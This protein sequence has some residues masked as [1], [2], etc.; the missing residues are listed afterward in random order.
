VTRAALKLSALALLAAGVALPAACGGG[1][2]GGSSGGSTSSGTG[3]A[4]GLPPGD[5]G[6]GHVD[7]AEECDDGNADD[8]DDCTTT[9]KIPRCGDGFVQSGEECDDGNFDDGDACVAGCVNAGC[10][11]GLLHKGVEDCDDGNQDNGD[12]CSSDCKAGQGCGNGT[13]EPPE[14]CDDGNSSNADAC[15]TS[16]LKATCGDGY[17]QIGAEECDDGNADDGDFCTNACK[18]N[19]PVSYGC[20]GI[21]LG[22]GLAMD[23]GLTGDSNAATDTAQG[24]CGGLDSPEIVYAVT[25]ADTG[26]LVVTM[27]GLE[28]S[29]PVL[30]ARSVDCQ[31]GMELGC[32]DSSF[33]GGTEQI[34]FPVL[35][36]TA[37]YVFA[38]GYPGNAGKFSLDLHM[39]SGVLGDTCPGNAVPIGP[40]A[41]VTLA[42][43]T[44]AAGSHYKGSGACST[45]TLTKDVVYS[46]KPTADGMLTVTLDP[47]YD[48]QLYARSGT[49]TTGMQIAC[50]EAAGIGG[51]EVITFPVLAD[52]TKYSVFVDGKS[53]SAGSYSVNFHLQ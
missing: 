53:G 43:N 37:Y 13:V 27:S 5:C 8:T 28:G 42:G 20:P 29:D 25:P 47:S 51:L 6:N 46:V 32:S 14:E 41:D 31:G 11:D 35:A 34:L 17:A 24:S 45:S 52:G 4:G 9:C 33:A 48:G 18:L 30:Y 36:N 26:T 10:G 38:D 44:A 15:L 49:C 21:P 16:C 2:T 40:E 1:G 22:V 12:S 7:G 23:N 50:A 3:G 39:Q 19:N